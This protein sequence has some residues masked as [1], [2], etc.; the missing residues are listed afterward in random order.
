MI[1]QVKIDELHESAMQLAERASVAKLRGEVDNYKSLINGAFQ[2]EKQ[3]AELLRDI[4][5]TEPTRSVLFRS[6]ASLA[7]ESDKLIEAEKL[8]GLGLS[9]NPPLAIAEELR[10]LNEV[11]TSNRHLDLR[12]IT[13]EPDELQLSIA[14]K[15]IGFGF[16]P[17][18]LLLTRLE[19]VRKLVYR[20]IERLMGKPYREMGSASSEIL[21]YGL[22]ISAPRP[23]SLSVSLKISHPKILLPGF[24]NEVDIPSP[25]VINEIVSCLESFSKSEEKNLKEKI[26]EE[27]YYRN[28]IGLAKQLSPDGD[29]V[30]QVGFTVL[31][32]GQEKRVSLIKPR[33]QI[34]LDKGSNETACKEKSKRVSVIGKLLLADARHVLKQKK[35]LLEDDEGNSHSVMVPEGMMSDIVKPLWEERVKVTG[36]RKWSSIVLEDIE[37]LS[38]KKE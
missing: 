24:G 31:H 33:D 36:Y 4:Y 25:R 17:S 14:G 16:A 2:F 15:H 37:K 38:P 35:I 19:N 27:A 3:A 30:R 34:D 7:I 29:E 10:D 12:G 6:A 5:D 18:E 11:V 32:E 13:L 1:D 22:Y 20:T 28:F 26:P 23:A 9:G 8:I 21:E